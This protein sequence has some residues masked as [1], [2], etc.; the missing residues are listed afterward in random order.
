MDMSKTDPTYVLAADGLTGIKKY[1]LYGMLAMLLTIVLTLIYSFIGI[2]GTN[3]VDSIIYGGSAVGLLII[4]AIIS[5]AVLVFAALSLLGLLFGLRDIRRSSLKGAS[6]YSGASRKLR[7]IAISLLILIALYYVLLIFAL[8]SSGA[9]ATWVSVISAI[10][11]IILIAMGILFAIKLAD[12]YKNL[13]KDTSQQ[14]FNTSA[15]IFVVSVIIIAAAGIVTLVSAAL[16]APQTNSYVSQGLPAP[17]NPVAL[18]IGIIFLIDYI[19][20][21]LHFYFGYSASKNALTKLSGNMDIL[22]AQPPK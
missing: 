6:I 20:L 16:S 19:L 2:T 18:A 22:A 13:S 4:I 12:V 8:I 10:F 3:L 21:T 9:G 15:T 14:R 1:F 17:Q 7:K 11:E 5:I